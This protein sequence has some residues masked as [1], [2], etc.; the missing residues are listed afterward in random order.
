MSN[1]SQAIDFQKYIFDKDVNARIK[2]NRDDMLAIIRADIKELHSD[3]KAL[4]AKLESNIK[5]LETKVD[6]D[7]KDVRADV[8]VLDAKIEGVHVSSSKEKP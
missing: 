6:A 8:K 1:T 2:E 3:I 5:V 7:I 4:D